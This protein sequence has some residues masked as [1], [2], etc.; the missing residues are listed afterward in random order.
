MKTFS[1]IILLSFASIPILKAQADSTKNSFQVSGELT[2]NSNGIAPIPAFALGDPTVMANILLQKNRFS[3]NPQLSYD[4]KL[5]PWIIDNWFH[6]KLLEKQKF[7]MRTGLNISMF[8][9]DYGLT[10]KE[11]WYGQLYLTFELAVKYKL[12]KKS[13]LSA[14]Y[15]YDNGLD[16]GSISGHFYNVVFDQV[17]IRLNRYLSMS[18]NIQLFYIDYT[19]NNDGLFISPKALLSSSKIPIFTFFQAI[20]PLTSNI[21]P[22]P[23][24]QWNLAVGYSFSTK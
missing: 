15:W 18:V 22:Y 20:Q 23:D 19:G 12:T 14:M 13:A 6:Y 8:F 9:S 3:Y 17:D 2:L 5:R 24:F 21:S 4:F 16:V 1:I 11:V 10:E 7:E